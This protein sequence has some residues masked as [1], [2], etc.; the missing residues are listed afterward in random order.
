M[1]PFNEYAITGTENEM[2]SS[3]NFHVFS[4]VRF[5][6]WLAI[7]IILLGWDIPGWN[8]Y[9]GIPMGPRYRESECGVRGLGI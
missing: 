6:S 4:Q 3:G 2:Q 8:T 1:L 7:P 5:R 9:F